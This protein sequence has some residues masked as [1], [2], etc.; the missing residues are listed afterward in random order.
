MLGLAIVKIVVEKVT[1]YVRLIQKNSGFFRRLNTVCID[2]G[3]SNWK[4]STSFTQCFLQ[5]DS[6]GALIVKAMRLVKN[7]DIQW[8]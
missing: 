8:W 6:I 7:F 3:F 1:N 2:W 5:D 4:K